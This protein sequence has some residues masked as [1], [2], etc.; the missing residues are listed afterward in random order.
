MMRMPSI[1]NIMCWEEE[2][3][4]TKGVIKIRKLKTHRQHN[5]Q[6]KQDKRTNNDLQKI[7]LN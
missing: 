4:E 5:I 2:F 6:K 7:Q 1:Q 3:E